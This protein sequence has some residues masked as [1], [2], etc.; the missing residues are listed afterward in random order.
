MNILVTGGAGYIGSVVSEE[1]IKAGEQVVVL[2]NL[3]RGHRAAVPEQAIFE[4]VDLADR[5]EI[6]HVLSEHKPNAIMHFAAHSLV[7][8]STQFPHRYLRDKE[9]SVIATRT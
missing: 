2:D 9:F 6:D 1:L 7:G 5:P 3:S 4:Q 8:E